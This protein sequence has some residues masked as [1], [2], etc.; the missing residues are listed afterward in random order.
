MESRTVITE[1]LIEWSKWFSA[2]NQYM[3]DCHVKWMNNF[4]HHVG[5]EEDGSSEDEESEKDYEEE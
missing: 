4:G 5:E 2:Q 1:A 3:D